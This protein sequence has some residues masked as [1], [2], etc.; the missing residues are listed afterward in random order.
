MAGPTI[1]DRHQRERSVR[2]KG[3]DTHRRLQPVAKTMSG[4]LEV[5]QEID[6]EDGNGGGSGLRQPIPNGRERQR[7]WNKSR[8]ALGSTIADVQEKQESP[9]GPSGAAPRQ[10]REKLANTDRNRKNNAG[11][12]KEDDS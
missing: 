12:R 3:G 5:E 10:I 11:G 7:E 2:P 8:V 6:A 4:G 9:S 1:A